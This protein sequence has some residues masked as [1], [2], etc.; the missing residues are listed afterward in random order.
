MRRDQGPALRYC[1]MCVALVGASL[2]HIAFFVEIA[3][4]GSINNTGGEIMRKYL[5]AATVL[6]LLILCFTAQAAS[7]N[8]TIAVGET[9]VNDIRPGQV[10]DY[11]FTPTASGEY[12][13]CINEVSVSLL[14]W[15]CLEGG[16]ELPE[17]YYWVAGWEGKSYTLEAGKTYTFRVT[18]M[19]GIGVM[20]QRQIRLEKVTTTTSL[21]IV[22]DS[23]KIYVDD[24]EFLK[25]VL[26]SPGAI[27][28]GYQWT[29]SNP[30]VA[31]IEGTESIQA[32][33]VPLAPGT[34]TI[35]LTMGGLTASYEFVVEAFQEI[36]AGGSLDVRIGLGDKKVLLITPKETGRYAVWNDSQDISLAVTDAGIGEYYYGSNGNSGWIYQL[37]AG[38]TYKLYAINHPG[39][40]NTA[41]SILSTIC[42]EKV[43][44]IQSLT[45]EAPD[46]LP[47]AGI[48][49]RLRAVAD[50]VYAVVEGVSWSC[51]DPDVL[52]LE[53]MDSNSAFCDA[54][55]LKPGKATVT[56]TVGGLSASWEVGVPKEPQWQ[57]GL[58]QT[59]PIMREQGSRNVFIP[60]ESGYYQ[61]T[62]TADRNTGF[63]VMQDQDLFG[64]RISKS[65]FVDPGRETVIRL[66]LEKDVPYILENF[67]SFEDG[68]TLTGSVERIK[69]ADKAVSHIQINSLPS[70]YEFG[71]DDYG[72][73]IGAEYLFSPLGYQKLEGLTFTVFYADGT[74]AAVDAGALNWEEYDIHWVPD[75][76][77]N[78]CPVEFML[79]IDG[80]APGNMI[81]MTAPGSVM[82]R[83]R[84]MGVSV[85][86]PL[87]VEPGHTH[88]L[89]FVEKVEP[90]EEAEGTEEHYACGICGK[91]YRD[92]FATDRIRDPQELVLRYMGEN[93]GEHVVDDAVLQDILQQLQPGESFE[94]P[95]PE[96]MASVTVSTQT[97]Q[98]LAQQ[99]NTLQIPTQQGTVFLDPAVL[100]AIVSQANGENVKVELLKL[101]PA[102]LNE[103]QQT[104]LRRHEAV[105]IISASV[106]CGDHYIHDFGGG[107]ATVRIPFAAEPGSEYEVIYIA[108]DGTVES[109]PS[110]YADGIMEF[111]TGHFSEYAIVRTDSS[112]GSAWLAL[113]LI[114]VLAAA[115]FLLRKTIFCPATNK[116]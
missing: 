111:T 94:L 70:G 20:G 107:S 19:S 60:S 23:Q 87:T 53:H 27:A 8:E 4:N 40:V 69:A 57:L 11:T 101:D 68:G 65:K 106:L 116:K 55:V 85:D 80:V 22:C 82:A 100:A 109:V 58:T 47:P 77:L 93:G 114:P 18:C 41:E 71:N 113:L 28:G 5:V 37:K 42:V 29:S 1:C 99:A 35:T 81:G 110:S 10:A 36:P 3:Y 59:M 50:P 76:D 52:K 38:V 63:A 32:A 39:P 84:Y 12:A 7:V 15:T 13:L 112:N 104:A 30:S 103:Q 54:T 2:L 95:V 86:F 21:G 61:F 108:D 66:Y 51:S 105:H 92:A 17:R 34:S 43:R 46:S 49:F 91:L 33:V 48:M 24:V 6:L 14:Q 79:L 67:G 62:V 73:V 89:T 9:K 75:C 45:L 102:Q 16:R 26:S 97:L 44:P 56:V 98:A 83:L 72:S 25:P 90:S 31:R 64:R 74:S 88:Q 115:A 96:G 78:G